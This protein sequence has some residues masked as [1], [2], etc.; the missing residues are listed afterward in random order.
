MG[1]AVKKRLLQGVIGVLALLLV[2]GGVAWVASDDD[3]HVPATVVDDPDLPSMI[4]GGVRLHARILGD[5]EAPVVIV[6]HGGPGDDLRALLPLSPLSDEYRVVLYD[7][8][9]AGLSERVPSDR[10]GTDDYVDELHGVIEQVAGDR[11]VDLIGHS[12]GAMLASAYLAR[13]PE[14][15]HAAI[16]AEPGFLTVEASRSFIA[17]VGQPSL[18]LPLLR[19]AAWTW[20]R[21]LHVRGPDPDARADW[22]VLQ[23]VLDAPA[24]IHPLAGYFCDDD[25]RTGHLPHHRFGSTASA[26][27]QRL[28]VD[29]AVD[30]GIDEEALRRFPGRVRLLTGSCDRLIGEAHQ[31]EHHLGLFA[32]ADLQVIEGAG[33]SMLG[34]RPVE[35]LARIRPLLQAPQATSSSADA[36]PSAPPPQDPGA[37]SAP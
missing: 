7:Q 8:R 9:G 4:V 30:L 12:W 13:H 10:L 5:R 2:A 36:P 22:F 14:R 21:S 27:V 25:P 3:P 6:L 17:K 1:D 29:G 23:L 34:E 20:L 16:L 24:E 15:V 35:S 19:H 11:P 31:R 32:H 37:S 18:S 28:A 26:A 33:H